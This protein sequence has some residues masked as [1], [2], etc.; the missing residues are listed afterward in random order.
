MK[1]EIESFLQ[2]ALAKI[3]VQ[4]QLTFPEIFAVNLERPRDPSHGDF[5]SNLALILAKQVGMPPRV[6]AERIVA[7]ISPHPD[8]AHIEIAGP[9]FINFKLSEHHSQRQF[10]TMWDSSL[11]G[12]IPLS[13]PYTV[14]VDYSSPNLAKEMHVGHLRSTII[15][16]AIVRVL[17]LKGYKVIR[18]NHV[19]DWGTQ[20]GMLLA[21][22]EDEENTHPGQVQLNDLESFYKQAKQRFDN[23]PD[24]AIRARLQVVLLQSG[25]SHCLE[26]WSRFIKL[27]LAHCQ[28][29]YERL[30]VSLQEKDVKAESAYNDL[31]PIIV[32][33][34][35]SQNLLVQHEGAQ[36]VFLDEFKGKDNEVLPIIVQK[37]DGGFLYSST[38]LAAI[39]YRQQ[40]LNADRVIYVV[41]ARQSLHFQQIFALAYKAGFAHPQMQLEHISFGMVLDKSG[42][43]FKSRDGGV[44]KLIDLLNEAEKRSKK[45]IQSKQINT[46]PMEELDEM[47]TIIGIS[48]IKYADLSKN[49][50]SDYIFDWDLMI[51]FEG[52]TAPYLLYAYT[53]INSLFQ[54]ADI[55]VDSLNESLVLATLHDTMLVKQII[56]F[57]EVID[58]L[59]IKA[60]PHLLCAYLY[61]LAGVFSSFYEACPILNQEDRLLKISRLKL[62]KMTSRILK[63]GLSLLGIKTL[64]RM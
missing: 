53:R 11:C 48:S 21:H 12:I 4:E 40:E 58:N 24:F 47:A 17:E 14:V 1:P 64:K 3:S 45:L 7:C 18:Q 26:L 55:N 19:G 38:D 43:P 10:K 57:P 36:C 39:S 35:R 22:L 59:A 34:L 33:S 50:T 6:L 16:D 20:F 31:L 60:A 30:G 62:A 54:K 15:G 61:E 46:F 37:K 51:S 23:D 25:D 27:S 5:S 8:I 9:G 49:R 2:Q 32:N 42:K 29:I 52:N 63:L 28:E 41:D 44:T 13:T 56:L